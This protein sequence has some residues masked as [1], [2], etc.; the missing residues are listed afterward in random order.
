MPELPEVETTLRGIES[1]I[2]NKKIISFV[3]REKKLRWLIPKNINKLVK[4][5]KINNA[6]R[7]GKYIIFQLDECALIIHLG[8]S[9][10]LRV[11]NK[12]VSPKKH[13]HWDLNFSDNWTLRYTDIRKFGVLDLT[14]LL[15]T[16]PSPRD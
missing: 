4:G 13:E 12:K 7:R 6:F 3:S 14:C 9:G 10:K 11:F 15:Y 8:M 5:K 2:L 16:S 1:K